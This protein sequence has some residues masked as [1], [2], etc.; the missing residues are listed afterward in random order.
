ME[1]E[2]ASLRES[3]DKEILSLI[4]KFENEKDSYFKTFE[5]TVLKL[6]DKINSL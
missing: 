6:E 2:K 3:F 5:S 1:S 4:E